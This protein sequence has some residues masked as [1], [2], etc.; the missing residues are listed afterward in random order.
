MIILA[1][2]CDNDSWY[3]LLPIPGTTKSVY[4]STLLIWYLSSHSSYPHSCH[5]GIIFLQRPPL[6]PLPL[7]L[8]S[9]LHQLPPKLWEWPSDHPSKTAPP[10][11]FQMVPEAVCHGIWRVWGSLQLSLACGAC[12]CVKSDRRCR[13]EVAQVNIVNHVSFSI[14]IYLIIHILLFQVHGHP[15]WPVPHPLPP[16]TVLWFSK[17]EKGCHHS[18]LHTQ[19]ICTITLLGVV[20]IP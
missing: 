14:L 16:G 9:S 15:P 4:N 12:I 10:F 2:Y 5:N 3:Y 6:M 20:G 19:Y 11:L 1:P 8:P 7:S 13:P 17:G 18:L